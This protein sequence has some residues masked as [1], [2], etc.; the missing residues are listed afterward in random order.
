MEGGA[1]STSNVSRLGNR[2]FDLAEVPFIA[3]LLR[4][5][6]TSTVVTR[7]ADKT[8]ILLVYLLDGTSG[9]SSRSDTSSIALIS[10]GT[11]T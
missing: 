9:A 10:D 11:F 6:S 8:V 5:G 7:R 3:R 4:N 2:S 1:D